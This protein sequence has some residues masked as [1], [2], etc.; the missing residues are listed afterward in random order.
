MTIGTV[1]LSIPLF[2][3]APDGFFHKSAGGDV[4]YSLKLGAMN[5]ALTV[6]GI[7]R[8]FDIAEDS[9]DGRMLGL[10][11]RA[12]DFV[13]ALRIGDSLPA[14]VLTGEPSWEITADH[15]LR[16]YQRLSL[17]LATWITGEE[18][19]FTSATELAQIAE[20]PNTKRRWNEAFDEAARRLG[21][22]GNGRERVMTLVSALAEDIA[23]IEALR[24]RYDEILPMDQSIQRLRRLYARENSVREIADSV[25]RLLSTAKERFAASFAE[26]DGQTGEILSVLRKPEQQARYI[27]KMRDEL[28]C[29]LAAWQALLARWRD[30]EIKRGE[31]TVVLLRETYRFLAPRYMPV[32]EWLRSSAAGG[33]SGRARTGTAV[34]WERGGLG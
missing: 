4:V 11:V 32:I 17:Q 3:L 28:Y 18:R 22:T 29:S 27:R 19:V 26:I 13:N 9:D 1:A 34:V 15:R 16:A 7:C 20:D 21:F 30:T 14:E 8:E 24:D 33:R 23:Y 5:A 2:R 10:I 6:A 31:H 25:A 12:L